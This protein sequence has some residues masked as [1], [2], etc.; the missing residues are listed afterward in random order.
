VLPK[1]IN[2]FHVIISMLLSLELIAYFST[3]LLY[4]SR[5]FIG[6]PMPSKSITI[7]DII[8]VNSDVVNLVQ[9][10]VYVFVFTLFSK[11]TYALFKP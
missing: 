6:T 5:Y 3:I 1:S 4:E 2:V 10:V 9:K 11:P 8:N 7:N